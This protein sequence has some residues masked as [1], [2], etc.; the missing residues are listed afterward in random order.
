MGGEAR[1]PDPFDPDNLGRKLTDDELSDALRV[2]EL[3]VSEIHRMTSG[4]VRRGDGLRGVMW[5]LRLRYAHGKPRG[6][7]P[8]TLPTARGSKPY[9]VVPPELDSR[10]A[11]ASAGAE[12]KA[13]G[14]PAAKPRKSRK[15]AKP[16]P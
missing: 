16:K 13:K 8:K 5:A 12:A 10:R 14:K 6:S 11:A 4:K 15:G 3:E 2:R 1:E 7:D 9:V